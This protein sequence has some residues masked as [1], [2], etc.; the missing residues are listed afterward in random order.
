MF[1]FVIFRTLVSINLEMV[2]AERKFT[3]VAFER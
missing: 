1:A 2:L 3:V